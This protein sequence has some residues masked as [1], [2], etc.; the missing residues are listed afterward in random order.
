MKFRKVLPVLMVAACLTG[1]AKEVTFDEFKEAAKA[2]EQVSYSTCT[3][4]GKG[5]EVKDGST[6]TYDKQTVKFTNTL[7]IGAWLPNDTSSV[8]AWVGETFIFDRASGVGKSDSIK[9]YLDGSSFQ[10][11]TE[12]TT[13]KFNKYGYVVSYAYNDGSSNYTLTFSWA[14]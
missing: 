9:Y 10:T 13:E 8:L 14:A 4:S 6:K 12:T 2:V 7:G 11:K 1:C 3:V 5:K